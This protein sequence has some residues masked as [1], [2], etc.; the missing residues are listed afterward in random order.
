MIK[1][2][3]ILKD[4]ATNKQ[5]LLSLLKKHTWKTYS[6]NLKTLWD[7]TFDLIK[8]DLSPIDKDKPWKKTVK[9]PAKKT[10]WTK[11]VKKSSWTKTSSTIKWMDFL[12]SSLW[13]KTWPKDV[14]TETNSEKLSRKPTKKIA[15]DKKT[16]EVKLEQ[17]FTKKDSTL[18]RA[19]NLTK[20]SQDANTEQ[21]SNKQATKIEEKSTESTFRVRKKQ[22][23]DFQS[24]TN[25]QEPLSTKK[26]SKSKVVNKTK[27]DSTTR[28]D[29]K[30][31]ISDTLKK[32]DKLTMWDTISVKE[33][34]ERIWVPSNEIIKVF[35]LNWMPVWVNSN[36][37]FDS[38]MVLA[39]DIWIKLERENVKSDIHSMFE[40]NLDDIIANKNAMSDNLKE[41]PPIVTIMWHVDHGKTK[42]LDYMRK[43]DVVAK[44]AWSITQS[45]WASEITHKDKKI[46]FI[47]T[48]WHELFTAMRARWAKITD[49][50]VIVVAADEWVKQQTVEAINHAKDANVTIMVAITK[51]DKPNTNIELIKSQL[52]EHE[53]ISEEWW[54]EVPFVSLSAMTWEW[55]DEF[56][57]YINLQAE[58][59]ELKYNPNAPAVWIVLEA[60]K[61]SKVWTIAT[62][63]PVTWTLNKKDS[64][65]AYNVYWRMR[66]MK[67]WSWKVVKQ[68][69]AWIPVQVMWFEDIPESW[70]IFEVFDDE[71]QAQKQVSQ[72]KDMIKQSEN[73]TWISSILDKMRAWENVE[74]KLILKAW[75][76][77]W[78]EALKYAVSKLELPE[79]VELKIIHS[80]VWQVKETDASLAEAS[81]AFIFGFDSSIQSVLR[82]KLEQKKI[83]FKNFTIIYEFLDYIESLATWMIKKELEEI[84][85]WEF[86]MMAMFFKK[87]NDMIIWWKVTD[88][89]VKN[90]AHFTIRRWDEELG[91][92]KIT[93]LKIDQENVNEVKA[94]RE[95][96][97]R[98]RTW[99][100]F[101]EWDILD[102]YIYE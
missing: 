3:D 71:R 5:E 24:K 67:D 42:L 50:A 44:E 74:L 69:Q 29:K 57:D 59:L 81:D 100:R 35:I 56:L 32:K 78:L 28:K 96:W 14:K 60:S 70:R 41:R 83:I 72:I 31:K 10:S 2:S 43:T 75:D 89:S 49:I 13:I 36:V 46:T 37:D 63:L 45:I 65:V 53:I 62:L 101:K 91:G 38:V 88:G 12:A 61:D 64:I 76:F 87:W 48:P 1:V 39:D 102:I 85:I 99:K 68:A 77:W 47:D 16:K 51:I 27:D 30:P 11:T 15:A 17:E 18:K 55:I 93:S 79:W 26:Y 34:S 52:S 4:Y 22:D 98:V 21:K 66:L 7:N 84:K 23:R 95:C 8:K 94:T 54:W 86:E 9:K 97:I 90:G 6:D 20:Q 73:K 92:W 25:G 19:R 40:W 33:L 58:M 80:E 82:K